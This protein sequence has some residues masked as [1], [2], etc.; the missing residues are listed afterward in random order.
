MTDKIDEARVAVG[1]GVLRADTTAINPP[2]RFRHC[3]KHMN[4]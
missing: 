4:Y 2:Q 1:Y 3:R